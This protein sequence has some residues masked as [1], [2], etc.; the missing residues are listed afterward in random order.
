M[1]SLCLKG[2]PSQF[3][4]FCVLVCRFFLWF[5]GLCIQILCFGKNGCINLPVFA[6]GNRNLACLGC[7]E[8]FFLATIFH[9]NLQSGCKHS[10]IQSHLCIPNHGCCLKWMQACFCEVFFRM[11]HPLPPGCSSAVGCLCVAMHMAGGARPSSLC[12]QTPMT[13]AWIANTQATH[14]LMTGPGEWP[15][16]LNPLFLW[17]RWYNPRHSQLSLPWKANGDSV[18]DHV[19]LQQSSAIGWKLL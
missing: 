15:S 1:F 5:L 16:P 19:A 10:L 12:A 18:C 9:Q 13:C 6:T 14:R 4:V 17:F 3:L 7:K 11:S 8:L 2:L